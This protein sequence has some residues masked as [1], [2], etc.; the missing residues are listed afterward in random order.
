MTPEP[1]SGGERCRPS[2]VATHDDDDDS[3][4][5]LA[6]NG[7]TRRGVP[8]SQPMP[9]YITTRK[10]FVRRNPG[11]KLGMVVCSDCGRYGTRVD[12]VH[13]GSPAETCGLLKDDIFIRIADE[14]VLHC[15]HEKLV[16]KLATVP[17][18]FAVE[19]AESF[20]MPTAVGKY[21]ITVREPRGSGGADAFG[22]TLP[23]VGPARPRRSSP[24]LQAPNSPYL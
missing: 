4:H 18:C 9:W 16:Q 6:F 10:V 8:S 2:L 11:E 20:Q 13:T 15:D 22:A 24:T 17:L 21:V 14:Y 3:T 7:E 19:V 12:K 5:T 1:S 23:G